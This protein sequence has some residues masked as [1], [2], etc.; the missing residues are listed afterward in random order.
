MQMKIEKTISTGFKCVMFAASNERLN[1]RMP[2]A[3]FSILFH[4]YGSG[5]AF[6]IEICLVLTEIF[7]RPCLPN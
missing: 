7:I 6:M 1:R 4:M 2:F 3:H 5:Q